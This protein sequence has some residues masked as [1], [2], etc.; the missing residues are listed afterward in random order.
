M[1]CLIDP[2]LECHQSL[3]LWR[4][5]QHWTQTLSATSSQILAGSLLLSKLVTAEH[6]AVGTF[7]VKA[8]TSGG[9]RPSSI[10]SLGNSQGILTPGPKYEV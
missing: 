9:N 2:S 10:A 4:S 8:G 7:L 1:R 5:Q 6:I 3:P